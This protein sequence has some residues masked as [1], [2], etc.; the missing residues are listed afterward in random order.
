MTLG[1]GPA[2]Q[3]KKL[4]RVKHRIYVHSLMYVY[5]QSE[6]V[7]ALLTRTSHLIEILAEFNQ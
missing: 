4:G 3:V 1:Q 7:L 5:S 2:M 6:R